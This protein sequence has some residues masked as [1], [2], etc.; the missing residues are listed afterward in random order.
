MPS[1]TPF[2]LALVVVILLTMSVA[3]YHRWQAAARER[4]SD[5]A[6]GYLF[7][8]VLRLVRLCLWISTFAYLLFPASVRWAAMSLPSWIRWVGAITGALCSLLIYWTLSSLGR[9]LTDIVVTRANAKLVTVRSCLR[10][11]SGAM[12]SARAAAASGSRSAAS[13]R[14][15]FD[16]VNRHSYF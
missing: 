16:S 1:E 12:I 9:N 13:S 14:A 3:I 11:S 2:R 5:K 4:I 15:A 6:E 10:R 7:A 8:A